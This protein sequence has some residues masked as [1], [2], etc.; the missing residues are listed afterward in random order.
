MNHLEKFKKLNRTHSHRRALYRNMIESLLKHERITTTVVKAKEIRRIVEKII[1]RAKEKTLS[2]IRI[3]N[4]LIKNKAML[5]RLFDEIGPRFVN[6]NGG[7]TRIYKLGKRKGDGADLAILEILPE[8]D[9]AKSDKKKKKKKDV[10]KKL[11][12]S[13]KEKVEAKSV[14]IEKES[15][16]VY[17]END[18]YTFNFV[19]SSG[20]VKLKG[21][22]YKSKDE[23]VKSI[24]LIKDII[25][26]VEIVDLEAEE[27]KKVTGPKVEIYLDA[28][29]KFVFRL[30]SETGEIV[31]S[32]DKGY[33]TKE[34]CI[35]D[36]EFIKS[37]VKN[38]EIIEG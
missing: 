24:E 36:I 22:K 27:V 31:G 10:E 5:K 12:T 37:V 2:N 15:F 19:D 18:N 3:V 29:E 11:D 21:E 28:E 23:V 25:D 9:T 13:K 38:S 33:A 16:Y 30:K 7:Y 35:K 14:K 1:T 32:I 34:E 6:R 20:N 17:S 26:K 8:I 4:R